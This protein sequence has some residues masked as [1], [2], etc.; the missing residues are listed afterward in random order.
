MYKKIEYLFWVQYTYLL[1][2]MKVHGAIPD[3]RDENFLSTDYTLYNN[4]FLDVNALD[5]E[6]KIRKKKD[7]LVP[8]NN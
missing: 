7:H 3:Q 8:S 2:S 1:L 6:K 4:V 5:P